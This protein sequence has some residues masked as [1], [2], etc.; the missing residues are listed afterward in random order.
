MLCSILNKG[1]GGLEGFIHGGA[2]PFAFGKF[3]DVGLLEKGVEG[4]LLLRGECGGAGE[5]R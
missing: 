3:Y 2:F 5:V 1:A 4:G